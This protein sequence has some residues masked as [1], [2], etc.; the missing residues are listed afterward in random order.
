MMIVLKLCLVAMY[1]FCGQAMQ[2]QLAE[3]STSI[4]IIHPDKNLEKKQ[5]Y[6]VSFVDK[7]YSNFY[8]L[9]KWF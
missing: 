6:A 5:I 8:E 1:Q 3:E 9:Q 4:P 7:I 2:H